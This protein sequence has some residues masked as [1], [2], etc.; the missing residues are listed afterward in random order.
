M[1]ERFI[2][3]LAGHAAARYEA[4]DRYGRGFARGKLAGDPVFGYLLRMGLIPDGA[5]VLDL[6]CGQ[7]VLAALIGAARERHAQG[8][9]PADWVPPPATLDYRGVDLLQRDIERATRA[10][11]GA[12]FE[13]GDVRTADFGR[14][15]VV[16]VLDVLHYIAPAE[17]GDVLARIRVALRGG[18]TLLMRVGDANGSLRFRWT[19]LADHVATFLRTRRIARMHWRTAAEWRGMLESLGFAVDARPMSGGTPFDNVLLVARY[20]PPQ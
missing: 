10:G 13:R 17:Q 12:R 4:R 8:D 9:W 16:I 19:V 1:T 6:G 7:G 5:S 3:T 2:R 18:G 15:D 11:G 20:H 14:A